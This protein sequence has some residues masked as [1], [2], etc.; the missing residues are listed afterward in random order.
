MIAERAPIFS[1]WLMAPI[2]RNRPVY[3]RVA[4]AA[5]IINLFGLVTSLFSMTVYD[6]VV[7]NNATASLVGLSIGLA[8]GVV[9]AFVL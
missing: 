5:V 7:P 1:E 9:L 6:R 2:R 8:L 3:V 4:L